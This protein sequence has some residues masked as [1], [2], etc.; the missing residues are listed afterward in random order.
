MFEYILALHLI[1]SLAEL[2]MGERGKDEE[3]KA[4]WR[5]DKKRVDEISPYDRSILDAMEQKPV[6][7]I[8]GSKK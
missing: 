5:R 1:C 3:N 8:F 6:M 7:I 2:K 4:R